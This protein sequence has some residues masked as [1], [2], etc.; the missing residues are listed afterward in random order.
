MIYGRCLL[1]TK[2]D[3]TDCECPCQ[4]P[5]QQDQCHQRT[6]Q[7]VIFN[8]YFPSTVNGRKIFAFRNTVV[9]EKVSIHNW[10]VLKTVFKASLGDDIS[11]LALKP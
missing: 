11:T 7:K 8:I 1:C 3:P 10:I 5:A 2:A 4:C 6:N 9:F